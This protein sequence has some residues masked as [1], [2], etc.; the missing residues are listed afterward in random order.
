MRRHHPA[1]EHSPALGPVIRSAAMSTEESTVWPES[2]QPPA[3]F[4]AFRRCAGDLQ[5]FLAHRLGCPDTA[6]DLV[7]E[8]FVRLAQLSPAQQPDNPR[9]FLF[10]IA[11]NL[12]T[13]HQRRLSYRAKYE[14]QDEAAAETPDSRPAAD[15]AVFSKQQVLRL[16]DAI[17]ELPP[18]CRDV[19]IL[20]KFHHLSYA[21][22]AAR[23]GITKSTVVK[24]MIKALDHC[25]RRVEEDGP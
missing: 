21:E 17:A 11:A 24:H 14:S 20:H 13:D 6:A 23:L 4:E 7:Q 16:H 5:R 22:V 19:F 2:P 3:L 1:N 12:A 8:T 18:K 25:R 9:A 10:R 15:E